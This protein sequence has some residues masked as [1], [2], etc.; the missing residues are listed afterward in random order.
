MSV[1]FKKVPFDENTI[2]TLT[3]DQIEEAKKIYGKVWCFKTYGLKVYLHKPSRM[4]MDNADK[5]GEIRT[6]MFNET[7]I[8]ESWLAGDKE[9]IT[10]DDAFYSIGR[11]LGKLLQVKNAEL[12]E[13]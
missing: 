13:L 6:S 4:A 2:K 5:Q 8:K 11:Q 3:K 12:E 9:V 10:N 7:I 1:K